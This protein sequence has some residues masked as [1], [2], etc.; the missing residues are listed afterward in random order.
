MDLEIVEHF[1]KSA[2]KEA[3]QIVAIVVG[4]TVGVHETV[5]QGIGTPNDILLLPIITSV[6]MVG[7]KTLIAVVV[8]FY[9]AKGLKKLHP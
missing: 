2:Y 8:S 3:E 7:V 5:T 6:A 4:T 9:A 1:F